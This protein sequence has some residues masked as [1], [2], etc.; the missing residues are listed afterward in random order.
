MTTPTPPRAAAACGALFS[1]GLFVA[2]GDGSGGWSAG[3]EVAA[4]AALALFLP[5]LAGLCDRLRVAAGDRPW[6]ATTALA[7]GVAGIALKTASSAPEIAI[8][9]AH[10]AAGTQLHAALDGLAGAATAASL[11]PLAVLCAAVAVL[12]LRTR[13]LPR[14]VAVG[15]AL[16]AAALAVNGAFVTT[17]SV[18][19]L[20]LFVLWTLVTSVALYR[21]AGLPA[22][23]SAPLA[24]PAPIA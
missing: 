4:L 1:I 6:L 14:P 2:V 8:H 16:T 15:A 24:R 17:D 13:A 5:F 11:Y 19:A 21:G 9:R 18:P 22:P 23:A 10:V 20:V 12:S 7:A 3:R